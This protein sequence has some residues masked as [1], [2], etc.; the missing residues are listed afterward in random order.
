MKTIKCSQLIYSEY[1]LPM[2]RQVYRNHNEYTV[3]SIL[4]PAPLNLTKRG[5]PG[6]QITLRGDVDI[7]GIK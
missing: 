2:H 6:H 5:P 7:G 1:V 3:Q 4:L